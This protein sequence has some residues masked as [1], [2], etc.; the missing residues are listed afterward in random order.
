MFEGRE[1]ETDFGALHAESLQCLEVGCEIG[2]KLVA[3]HQGFLRLVPGTIEKVFIGMRAEV[4]AVVKQAMDQRGVIGV[5][6][7][8]AS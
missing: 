7:K 3:G 2:A 8:V 5:A 6:Q 1:E 4:M